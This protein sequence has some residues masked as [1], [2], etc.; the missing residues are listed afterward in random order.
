MR[1]DPCCQAG[2]GGRGELGP[3]VRAGGARGVRGHHQAR[4]TGGWLLVQVPR[5]PAPT[6]CLQPAGDEWILAETFFYNHHILIVVAKLSF[7][8]VSVYYC[9]VDIVHIIMRT[10]ALNKVTCK[11]TAHPFLSSLSIVALAYWKKLFLSQGSCS[12]QSW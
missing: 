7:S 8:S 2:P 12:S 6:L 11:L 5:Q 4:G 10:L 9:N 1:G 3:G